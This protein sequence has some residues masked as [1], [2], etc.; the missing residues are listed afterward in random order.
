MIGEGI[1]FSGSLEMMVNNAEI[2]Y[3]RNEIGTAVRN[4]EIHSSPLGH[5]DCG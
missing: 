5:L 4:D 2:F 3:K 1:N